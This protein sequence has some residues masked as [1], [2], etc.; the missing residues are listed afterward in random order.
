M[1]KTFSEG[2][3]ELKRIVGDGELTGTITVNQVYAH[4]I[5]DGMSSRGKPSF[6][7]NHPR[8]G[9]AMFL[10]GPV[11]YRRGE[12]IQRWANSV[13]TGRLVPETID[14]LFTFRDDVFLHAPREFDILRNSTELRLRDNDVPAFM[15]PPLIPRLS[16]AEIKAIRKAASPAG[17]LRTSLRGLRNR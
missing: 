13:L 3:S 11:K 7:F 8:G 12:V 1:T 4:W 10:S 9:Q 5:D 15:L 6:A 14:I 16:E 2:I 17:N